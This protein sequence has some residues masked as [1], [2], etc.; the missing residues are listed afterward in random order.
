MPQML[1]IPDPKP[2]DK[3]LG[4]KFFKKAP[5]RPGVY[6]MKNA[7]DEVVYVGKAK[8]LK[9]RLANYRLANPDRMPRRHLK[10]VNEVTKIE[11]RHCKSDAG[12]IK[13]ER[14]LIREL[15]PK[16]NRAG[17]W[18]GKT[19]FL[20]WRC[21]QQAI[22]LSVRETPETGWQRFGPLGGGATHL[23]RSLARLM[24]LAVNPD[25]PMSKM[26]AGWMKGGFK[27]STVIKCGD[28]FKE[29]SAAFEQYFFGD[30][31]SFVLWLGEKFSHRIVPFERRV[32]DAELET[33]REFA[34]RKLSERK[35]RDQMTLI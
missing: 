5:R 22:E 25:Q 35:Q 24:W 31:E 3:R 7:Q 32:I 30:A 23:Q 28:L 19:K 34:K 12:A 29:T 27:E 26:P 16:F 14:K 21:E 8:D 10:M 2:L 13:T 9:Q 15:R 18:P 33:L 11:L 1:L 4:K 20:V 6:L 17:V